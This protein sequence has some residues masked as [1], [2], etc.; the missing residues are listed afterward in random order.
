MTTAGMQFGPYLLRRRL[1]TGGM[2]SVWT[3]VDAAGRALV[4]KR[5]L[6]S[7]AAE[8]EF[9]AMFDREATLSA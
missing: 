9:V 8:A 5:I 1:S 2:A 7:L 4:V 3:A 6:P